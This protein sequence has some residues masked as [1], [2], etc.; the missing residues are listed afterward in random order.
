MQR[1]LKELDNTFFQTLEDI[2]IKKDFQIF[3]KDFLTNKELEMFIKRLGIA[4]WLKKERSTENIKTNLDVKP[5]EIKLVKE[6]METKG[7]KLAIKKIE[8]EE[9]ANKWAENIKKV[10][11]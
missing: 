6:K 2:K 10:L 8:A 5:E 11:K 1:L 7:V 4:Y 3:F 9:W